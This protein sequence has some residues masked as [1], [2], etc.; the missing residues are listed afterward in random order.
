MKTKSFV[1][2]L[3]LALCCVSIAH[4]DTLEWTRQLGTSSND[5]GEGV[6]ADGLVVYISGS[7][8]GNLGAPNAGDRDAFVAKY[9]TYVLGDMDGDGD[10]DFED[11]G[12][13]VLALRDASAYEATYGVPPELRGDLDGDGD[14]D[15]D[16]FVAIL[17]PPPDS[18]AT[19]AIPEPG[20]AVLLGVAG[21][22]LCGL[23]RRTRRVPLLACPA[24][25]TEE[26]ACQPSTF[27]QRLLL[28]VS[29]GRQKRTHP[30]FVV[31]CGTSLRDVEE[32]RP[33]L[34]AARVS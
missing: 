32:Q 4:A 17:I 15:F 1:A 30:L 2:F 3:S 11:I 33:G 29:S 25:R 5:I 23:R 34:S 24:V 27:G 16:D 19:Q 7:T 20:T 18:A 12:A 31:Q 10:V 8:Y 22:V 6:S 13:L 9:R 28:Q 14:N 21:L 26:T